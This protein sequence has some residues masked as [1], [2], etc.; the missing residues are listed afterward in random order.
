MPI[1]KRIFELP[2]GPPSQV[3]TGKSQRQMLHGGDRMNLDKAIE[4]IY[5]IRADCLDILK[6]LKAIKAHQTTPIRLG[7][8]GPEKR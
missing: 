7:E 6:E 8:Q 3:R 1:Q 2:K 4:T 5:R